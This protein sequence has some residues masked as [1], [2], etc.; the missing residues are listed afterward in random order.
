MEVTRTGPRPGRCPGDFGEPAPPSSAAACSAFPE[1]WSCVTGRPGAGLD[2]TPPA[3]LC[4]SNGKLWGQEGPDGHLVLP[5]TLPCL[6]PGESVFHTG[7]STGTCPQEVPGR[8]GGPL[9]GHQQGHV[10]RSVWGHQEKGVTLSRDPPRLSHRGLPPETSGPG[11]GRLQTL[12]FTSSPVC[13][14]LCT[15]VLFQ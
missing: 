10:S 6:G 9:A 13:L 11:A 4:P 1:T 3:A 8:D 2:P 5:V 14:S 7:S 12:S 15:G